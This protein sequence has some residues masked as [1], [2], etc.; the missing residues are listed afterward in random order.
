[1]GLNLHPLGKKIWDQIN[2]LD[3]GRTFSNPNPTNDRSVLGQLTHN[4]VTDSVGGTVKGLRD[5]VAQS[6]AAQGFKYLTA[7]ATRNQQ[8][9][10]NAAQ[11]FKPAFEHALAT[12][13]PTVMKDGRQVPNPEFTNY[14]LNSA[15]GGVGVAGVRPKVTLKNAPAKPTRVATNL[16]E[17]TKS[18]PL[19]KAAPKAPPARPPAGKTQVTPPAVTAPAVKPKVT[20]KQR[21]FVTSVKQSPEVS[22]DVRAQVSGTY[23]VR[24]TKALEDKS[25]A[26]AKNLD[27]STSDVR[28]RLENP[29]GTIDDRTVSD[30]IAV[31]KAHDAKGN[32]QAAS[33]IY[34]KLAEHLT[35]SGQTVQA[36]SLLDNLTPEGLRFRGM[37]E[38]KRAGVKVDKELENKIK[39]GLDQVRATKPGTPER[40][41]AVQTYKKLISDNIPADLAD[42]VTS[43]WKAGLLTG[44]RTQTGNLLSNTTFG[45]LHAVSDPLAVA[46]DKAASLVTGQRSKTL[47]LRGRASGA[48]EGAKK[49]AKYLRTGVDELSQITNKFD[50]RE[51]KF[52]NKALNVYVNGV[53]RT[54]GAADKPFRYAQ[55]RNSLY[56]LAKADGLNK[57]LRGADLEQHVKEFVTDP[58]K[59]ALQT[60]T[61]EAAKAVLGNETYLSKLASRGRQ[62][63]E[64]ID[65]P[66][67]KA[68]AKIATGVLMPFTKVPSAFIS[69]VLDF[70]PV[71]AI[72]EVAIQASKRQL[73]QRTLATALSEATTGTALTYMGAELANNGLLSGAYPNDPKEQQRW[74]AEGIQPNSI[75]VGDT[76]LSLNYFGPIGALFS[77]GKRAVD[78][79]A[80]GGNAGDVAVGFTGGTLQDA[81]GQSFLQG[82]S[83][84]LDAVQDPKRYAKNYAKNQSGSVVPTLAKDV[85]EA[86][87]SKQRTIDTPKD[88]IQARIP[89]LRQGLKPAQDVYGNELDR[90]STPLS[91]MVNPLRPSDAVTNSVKDEVR[92]LHEVDPNNKDLQ[93]TPTPLNKTVKLGGEQTKLTD[94]QR[95]ELQKRVGQATQ[96]IW[97]QLIRTPEYKKLNDIEK[98]G[99]LNRLRLDTTAVTMHDYALENNIG[100]EKELTKRQ[101]A[102]AQGGIDFS[103]YTAKPS[104]RTTQNKKKAASPRLSSSRR[105]KVGRKSTG[106]AFKY[107]VSPM[108]GGQSVRPRVTVKRV[109]RV[110]SKR[111]ANKVAAKPKVTLKKATA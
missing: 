100:V 16:D 93:V 99:V 23:K 54:M 78:T 103:T 4:G 90:K 73:D 53:F 102:I 33:D 62:A 45:A 58:P 20:G 38:L 15:G 13:E 50:Q 63:A 85:A 98:A 26:F 22:Q 48:V 11:G 64:S 74:K 10:N 19:P 3:N 7:F 83:G 1:M 72:K 40:S 67:G 14:I 107:A 111:A 49:G 89:G 6:P 81:L 96:D 101:K 69:R 61:D 105:S 35:K 8:A 75:K 29:T 12:P 80:E 9:Q 82:V 104:D 21:G 42:K 41:Y 71:G 92:R 43:V 51:I 66:A 108:A 37:R 106:S 27:K 87:D 52:K 65:N 28:T 94:K 31:A 44:I 5:S 70:T 79:I 18:A 39:A 25:Q 46:I 60:A 57:G 77:Q 2:P 36:A 95:Y 91:T 59:A 34:D 109:G 76:W 88:A 17:A 110:K 55:L 84:A 47:A 56:D 32:F 30:A 86:T 24:S 68:A 97:G